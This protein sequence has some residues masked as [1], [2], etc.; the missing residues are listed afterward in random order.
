MNAGGIILLIAVCAVFVFEL[1]SLI[2]TL[3]KKRKKQK[4]IP[5]NTDESNTDESADDNS[6]KEVNA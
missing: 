2:V 4:S 5:K 3:V 1:T 6:N